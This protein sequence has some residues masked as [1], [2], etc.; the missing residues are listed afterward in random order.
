M[1]V[2]VIVCVCMYVCMYVN[3]HVCMSACVCM[4][5]CMYV[6]MYVCL[7]DLPKHALATLVGRHNE[8]VT[9]PTRRDSLLPVTTS[10][11]FCS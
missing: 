1:Y 11:Y 9:F 4:H 3:M 8:R 2:W 6:K 5:A 10:R 7:H